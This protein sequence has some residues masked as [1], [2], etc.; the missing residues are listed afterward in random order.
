MFQAVFEGCIH[1]LNL[2]PGK[3]VFFIIEIEEIKQ[4]SYLKTS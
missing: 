2:R 4:K 1:V 3:G